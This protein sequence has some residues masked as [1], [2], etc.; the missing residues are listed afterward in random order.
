MKSGF[1]HR[2]LAPYKVVEGDADGKGSVS[3]EEGAD[4]VR[5]GEGEE[6]A[7][8]STANL[9]PAQPYPSS[10]TSSAYERVQDL[11]PPQPERLRESSDSTNSRYDR[12]ER[13]DEFMPLEVNLPEE[14]GITW[15]MSDFSAP[16]R[17]PLSYT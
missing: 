6:L 10:A 7:T 1:Q 15:Q 5:A 9:L 16:E 14:E 12:V 17:V 13:Q 8:L 2:L 3:D 4:K 11:D